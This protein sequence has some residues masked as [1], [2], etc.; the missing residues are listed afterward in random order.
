MW[1]GNVSFSK[2][3]A[4]QTKC[5]LPQVFSSKIEGVVDLRLHQTKEN[6]DRY[7]LEVR[8][9]SRKI[10]KT[11]LFATIIASVLCAGAASA[12][13]LRSE[14]KAS[15]CSGSCITSTD[16]SSGCVCS[17]NTPFTPGFCST[18]LAGFAPSG[19]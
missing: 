17:R 15:T 8:T 3:G 10:A 12:R 18:H 7:S 13:Q 16:C 6:S 14:I 19:K 11:T 9:M 4:K 5:T 1:N 2:I